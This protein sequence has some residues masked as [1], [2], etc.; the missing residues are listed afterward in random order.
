MATGNKT[1]NALD[2]IF[3]GLSIF[4]EGLAIYEK[5]MLT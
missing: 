4:K 2:G 5:P 1:R 3:E